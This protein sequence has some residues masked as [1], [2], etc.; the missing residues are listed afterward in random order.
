MAYY[1]V[2]KKNDIDSYVTHAMTSR[3]FFYWGKIKQ[4]AIK[5]L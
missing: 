5:Y 4:V 3:T 1:E 2:L